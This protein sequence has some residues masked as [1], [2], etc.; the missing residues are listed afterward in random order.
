[1]GAGKESEGLNANNLFNYSV[2]HQKN[3]TGIA[4]LL[5]LRNTLRNTLGRE[6]A[7]ISTP[8]LRPPPS[9]RLPVPAFKRAP[10]RV[11][12]SDM[13]PCTYVFRLKFRISEEAE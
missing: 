10:V 11:R 3:G 12:G 5:W 6:C 13:L 2:L 8:L 7:L 9:D 1:M 4:R